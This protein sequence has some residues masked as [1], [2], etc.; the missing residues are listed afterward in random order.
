MSRDGVIVSQLPIGLGDLVAVV[1]A[2]GGELGVQGID[3][4]NTAAV[5]T[6]ERGLVCA[7]HQPA[8]MES[9]LELARLWPDDEQPQQVP[10]YWHD[11]R[12]GPADPER[13]VAIVEG[14]AARAEGRLIL[15]P[16]RS[17][18]ASAA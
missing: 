3:R 5:L 17:G 14:L 1:R 2:S 11:V 9:D 7:V 16:P 12:V 13:G 6:S 4:L 8:L 18:D 15:A 10:F